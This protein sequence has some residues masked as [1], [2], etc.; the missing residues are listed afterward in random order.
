MIRQDALIL[1]SELIRKCR[2]ENVPPY[3][4]KALK[5]F[6]DKSPSVETRAFAARAMAVCVIGDTETVK[7]SEQELPALL[8][9]ES[10]LY[11]LYVLDEISIQPSYK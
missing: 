10:R 3:F 7:K 5:V 4:E 8:A 2:P 11:T 1:W 6:K 9:K